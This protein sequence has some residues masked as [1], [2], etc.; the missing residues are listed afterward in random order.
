M[1]DFLYLSLTALVLSATAC[2]KD[3]DK[4]AAQFEIKQATGY[5]A[6]FSH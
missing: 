2:S 1:R 5:S 4:P 3:Q 6:E